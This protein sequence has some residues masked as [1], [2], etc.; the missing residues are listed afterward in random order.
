MKAK[1]QQRS[2]LFV[3]KYEVTVLSDQRITLPAGVIRQLQDHGVRRVFPGRLP[4]L[5]AL[6]LCPETF[7]GQWTNKLKKSFPR[8]ESHSGAKDFLIPWQPI[9]WD[10]KGR[11]VLPRRAREY[12]G[13]QPDHTVIILGNDGCFELWSEERFDETTQECEAILERSIQPLSST[14][15]AVSPERI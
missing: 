12:A 3:G 4:C 7:W 8:L 13:I 6:V 10:A 14:G 9:S 2:F 11:I 1:Q 15:K 5:R